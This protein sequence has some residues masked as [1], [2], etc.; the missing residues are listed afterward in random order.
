VGDLR[1]CQIWFFG[2]DRDKL[3]RGIHD[4]SINL[5]LHLCPTGIPIAFL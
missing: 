3:G 4:E 1:K 2:G 5:L